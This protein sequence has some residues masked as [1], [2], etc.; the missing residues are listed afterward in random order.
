MKKI[1]GLLSIFLGL[2]LVICMIFA[3][4]ADFSAELPKNSV[5]ALKILTGFEYFINYLPAIM[6]TGFVVS[7]SVYFGQNSEGST[8]RFSAAMF[9]RFKTIMV[10]VIVI[11][12]VLTLGAE[13][14]GVLIGQ[15]KNRIVNRPKLVSEYIKVGRTLYEKGYYERAMGYADA[16]LKLSPKSEE[17]SR[18]LD[19]AEVASNQRRDSNIRI[20]LYESVENAEK[21]DHVVID[22]NQI[23]EVYEY[24]LRAQ[25]YFDK[26][27]WFNAHYYAYVGMNLASPKDP[28]LEELRRIATA[29]WNNLSEYHNL[30]KTDEQLAFGKK[31]EGYLALLEKDDLRAYYIFNELY[32]SSREFQSDPDV[33][34]YRAIA[35]NRINEK[36]F[37]IDE[38][39]EL[40]SFEDAN[41]IY[42]AYKYLDGS[43]DII[44]FKGV[45]TVQGT[46]KS[47]QY[48]RGLFIS[49]VDKDGNLFRT[50][51]VP[52]AKVL[53]VSVETFS[54][55]T[56][57]L[58]GL[59]DKVRFVPYIMLRSVERDG[60]AG[61]YL[62]EYTYYQE[63]EET[64]PEHLMFSIPYDDFI[65]LENSMRN[66]SI[67][68]LYTL[69]M[70]LSR[71]VKYGFSADVFGAV[72]LN[73]IF[74][75]FWMI[76]I[77][78][79]LATFAWNNRT[80]VDQY[81]KFWW[82]FVFP[83]FMLIADVF[84]KASMFVFKLMNYAILASMGITGAM[85]GAFAVYSVAL[86][87][88]SL[89]FLGRRSLH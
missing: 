65:M 28:N 1:F 89:F 83:V 71:T 34:F 51:S 6:M 47:I 30:A 75:P 35:E 9:A 13:V 59:D 87:V 14:F 31:Y 8:S 33:I 5:N 39:L 3:A 45:T 19:D 29:A 44:Y 49:S 84:Y 61:E 42:F 79:M 54:P 74:Y 88:C 17:A 15:Q 41:D 50:M 40:E 85:L 81:F 67:I 25:D 73:R 11:A 46:G 32:N 12:F 78:I 62:P 56:R 18:L 68:P 77:F 80:N 23:A 16:A 26:K 27:E 20:K 58:M 43:Q 7:C 69:F 52:Y 36:C 64:Y 37:F 24:Y 38:T 4:F 72:C 2:S 82:V 21:V 76:I 10:A 66:P 48:L 55:T 22:P 70:L 53:P 63:M 57:L 60:P 86:V